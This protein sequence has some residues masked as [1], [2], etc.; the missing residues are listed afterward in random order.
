MLKIGCPKV[1]II[2]ATIKPLEKILIRRELSK[3]L[4]NR[5]T[6]KKQRLLVIRVNSTQ[7]QD[8]STFKKLVRIA[9]LAAY[10]SKR[11]LNYSENCQEQPILA[12]TNHHR[13]QIEGEE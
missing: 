9:F 6:A 5:K 13:I 3:N 8:L 7:E 10:L 2:E 11:S 12:S 4:Y 1:R